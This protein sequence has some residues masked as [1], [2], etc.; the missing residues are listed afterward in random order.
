[1]IAKYDFFKKIESDEPLALLFNNVLDKALVLRFCSSPIKTDG[2]HDD[3]VCRA[4]YQT[5]V[6]EIYC[7]QSFKRLHEWI[8]EIDKY[9]K[10]FNFSWKYYATAERIRIIKEYGSDDDDDWDD[11]GNITT[12]VPEDKLANYSVIQNLYHEDFVDV[13]QDVKPEDFAGLYAALSISFR[14][15]LK[16]VF[17]KELPM[18]KNVNG[19]MVE[20]SFAERAMM[21]AEESL[22]KDNIIEAFS[23]VVD[24]IRYIVETIQSLDKK[25][26]NKEELEEIRFHAKRLL[27]MGR[28]HVIEE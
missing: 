15:G 27:N 21:D 14:N 18:Y 6:W 19:E 28:L 7:H 8:E 23:F 20:I 9:E 10:E 5:C 3:D 22:E 13:V 4:F 16:E 1:M 2:L 17:G 26:D 24:I 25:K 12:E 11:D